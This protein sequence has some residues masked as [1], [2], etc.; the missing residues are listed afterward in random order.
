MDSPDNM[1]ERME[2]LLERW[3]Q[4][5]YKGVLAIMDGQDDQALTRCLATVDP[6]TIIDLMLKV[7]RSVAAMPPWWGGSKGGVLMVKGGGGT[8]EMV[9]AVMGDILGDQVIVAG[10]AGPKVSVGI[11]GT[12]VGVVYLAMRTVIAIERRM[13]ENGDSTG[14]S[15]LRTIFVN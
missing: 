9:L 12:V 7:A 15:G 1:R 14:L 6:S 13:G 2:I 11:R 3:D 5:G 4:E 10:I 8:E